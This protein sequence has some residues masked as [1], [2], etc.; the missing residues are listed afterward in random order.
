MILFYQLALERLG[1]KASARLVD[2]VQYV[3]RLRDWDFD[4][5]V[6]VWEETLGETSSGIIGARTRPIGPDPATS[7]ALRTQPWTP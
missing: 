4:I 1:I 5:I 2:D 3:N 6:A 7:L